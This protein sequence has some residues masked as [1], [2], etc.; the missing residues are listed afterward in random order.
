[1]F[2]N[3]LFRAYYMYALYTCLMPIVR[4]HYLHIWPGSSVGMATDF[5]LDDA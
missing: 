5:V 2:N 1:M 3:Y 4:V